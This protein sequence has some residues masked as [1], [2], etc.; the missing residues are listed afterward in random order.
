MKEEIENI[1]DII[2]KNWED[3]NKNLNE[4]I[5][6]SWLRHFLDEINSSTKN[7]ETSRDKTISYL[8][9]IIQICENFNKMDSEY[10]K[11]GIKEVYLETDDKDLIKLN[12]TINKKSIKYLNEIKTIISKETT[13][14]LK[15][16][17]LDKLDNQKNNNNQIKI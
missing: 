17:Y 9:T 7:S 14:A 2:E 8:N 3:I 13:T 10:N 6:N 15:N 12:N 1:E 4:N 16:K 5:K 11:L